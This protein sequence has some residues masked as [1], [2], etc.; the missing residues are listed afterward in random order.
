[1]GTNDGGIH[2][3]NAETGVEEWLFM[4]QELLANQMELMNNSSGKHLYGIDGHITHWI[5]DDDDDGIIEYAD[6]DR[7]WIFF[8]MR[9]AEK[10]TT[11]WM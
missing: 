7:V 1:M 3:F 8:G 2:M 11:P 4:P 10:T 5:Y 9:V 6:G